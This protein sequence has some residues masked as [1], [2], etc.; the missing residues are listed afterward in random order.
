MIGTQAIHSP[1][2]PVYRTFSW[3]PSTPIALGRGGVKQGRNAEINRSIECLCDFL[4]Q[5]GHAFVSLCLYSLHPVSSKAD[6]A[7][8]LAFFKAT[9]GPRWNLKSGWQTDSDIKNWYGVRVDLLGRVSTLELSGNGLIGECIFVYA[10]LYAQLCVSWF[11]RSTG[12]GHVG[13][14]FFALFYK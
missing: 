5:I 6:R 8:L 14:S 12:V 4:P 10:A 2:P 7:V 1:P 13:R 9:N 3:R 11:T